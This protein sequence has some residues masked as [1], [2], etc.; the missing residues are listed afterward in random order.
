MRDLN[1]QLKQL[2]RDN[3]DGSYMTQSNRE[4]LLALVA[5]QLQELGFRGMGAHS[6]K[7]KHV[8]A[9]VDRW[10]GEAIC[11]RN[12]EE[13]HECAALVGGEGEPA[14]RRG[15]LERS[16]RD[17]AAAAREQRLQG[18]RPRERRASR[19]SAIRTCA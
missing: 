4:R 19:R 13:P 15:T 2:C 11:G 18:G 8:E 17:R 3:R 16:L 7:P 5:N 6:L 9:L 1:Y 14:K 10:Q 12:A